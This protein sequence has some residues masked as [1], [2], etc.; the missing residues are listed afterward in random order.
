MDIV[1]ASVH[2]PHDQLLDLRYRHVPV[3]PEMF[4]GRFRESL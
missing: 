2:Y 3:A 4:F 1:V